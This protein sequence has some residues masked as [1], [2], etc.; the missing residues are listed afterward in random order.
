MYTTAWKF[1]KPLWK[2]RK[3][4]LSAAGKWHEL[5]DMVLPRRKS[6]FERHWGKA[7]M[8]GAGIGIGYL[9]YRNSCTAGEAAYTPQQ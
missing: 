1:R 3:Q 4:L 5:K 9:L 8:A 7:L 6:A 2:Y